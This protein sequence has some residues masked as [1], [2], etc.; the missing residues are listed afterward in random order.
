MVK[1]KGFTRT[2]PDAAAKFLEKKGE[3]FRTKHA[4]GLKANV[5]EVVVFSAGS[6]TWPSSAVL[7]ALPCTNPKAKAM[8]EG[9]RVSARACS[10]SH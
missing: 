8:W 3:G 5:D 9:T 4:G 7:P 10:I 2:G 6:H 1:G